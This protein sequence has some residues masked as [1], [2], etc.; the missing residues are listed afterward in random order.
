[1][2]LGTQGRNLGGK[3]PSFS[4]TSLRK[5]KKR[6]LIA[7]SAADSAAELKRDR[8]VIANARPYVRSSTH[9]LRWTKELHDSF[10]RAVKTLGGPDDATPKRILQLMDQDG[11]TLAH[12]KSH[13]QMYRTG[14][15]NA[16]GMPVNADDPV[17][18]TPINK[19]LSAVQVEKF[20]REAREVHMALQ[21]LKEGR[22]SGAD[23]S[24][25]QLTSIADIKAYRRFTEMAVDAEKTKLEDGE[26]KTRD[27]IPAINFASPRKREDET[28][29]GEESRRGDDLELDLSMA[30]PRAP[31]LPTPL[32]PSMTSTPEEASLSLSLSV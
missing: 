21:L 29:E 24:E 26:T 19:P 18:F 12:V 5:K 2:A 4:R 20:Q 11:I 17:Q 3:V 7:L 32:C 23:G 1:M 31:Q 9:K 25:A 13:L 10:L 22:V 6:S 16:H 30:P 8:E 28:E 27:L 14:K 15:I